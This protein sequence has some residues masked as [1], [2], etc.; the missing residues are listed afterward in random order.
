MSWS[1]YCELLII[2]DPDRRSFYEKECERSGWSVREMKRQIATSL[3]ERLLFSDGKAN[4]EKVYELATK[5]QELALPEDI[6]KDP[7]CFFTSMGAPRLTLTGAFH[8]RI[9][10]QAVHHLTASHT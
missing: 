4:K 10:L 2:S 3:F 5:G 7:Y 8:I 9:N 6:V 1:H